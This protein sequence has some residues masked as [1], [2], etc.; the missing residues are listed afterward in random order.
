[1]QL[2]RGFKMVLILVF[3]SFYSFNYFINNSFQITKNKIEFFGLFNQYF[4]GE[5]QQKR[6]FI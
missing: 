1:M 4:I 2:L 5:Q 6:N 3:S